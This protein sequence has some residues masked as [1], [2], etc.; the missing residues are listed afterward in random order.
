MWA[1]SR[2]APHFAWACLALTACHAPVLSVDDAAV[3][4]G[5]ETRLSAYVE[6]ESLPWLRQDLKGTPV[7][8][9]VDGRDLGDDR[10]DDDG[11][12]SV[13]R[14]LPPGAEWYEAR[15]TV[16]GRQLYA[17]GRLFTWDDRRVILAVDIDHTIERTEYRSLLVDKGED[18]S[19]PLKRSADTLRALAGDFH[20][21][22]LTGRPRFLLEK[23]RQWL[24]DKEFPDGPVLTAK[25]VRDMFRP[26]LFKA[27]E[28]RRL[29]D[30]W[31]NLLIGIGDKA[32]DADAYGSNDMLSLIVSPRPDRDFP[33]H[34]IVLRDWKTLGKFFAQNREILIDPERLKQAIRGE[35]MLR[36][37]LPR[38]RKQ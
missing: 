2:W 34:A 17:F 32:S 8:F 31:P 21:L 12:A 29:R 4:P 9:R 37:P 25:G 3:R 36:R 33:P 10:T 16:N 30:A 13:E 20:I 24:K 26:G 18:E 11:R 19:D 35:V 14:K 27:A 1:N 6:R 7:R 23:T 22:Y 15:A 38:Y 28:L 5:A